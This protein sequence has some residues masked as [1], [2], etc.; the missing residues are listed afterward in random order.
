MTC[1]YVLTVHHETQPNTHNKNGRSKVILQLVFF[2]YMPGS[3]VGIA[4]ELRAGRSGDRI[5]VG[6]DFPPFQ[7]DPGAHP[8][9]YTM[10]TGSFTGLKRAGALR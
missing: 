5:P 2:S 9:S 4:T 3:S 7:T 6:R 10:G 1:A 8:A